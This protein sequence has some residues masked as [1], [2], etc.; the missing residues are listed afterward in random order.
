MKKLLGLLSLV[1]IS[2][3]SFAQTQAEKD[4]AILQ[5]YFAEHKIKATKTPSGLY[6]VINQKGS[7]DNAKAGQNVTV[8][9]TGKLLDGK[10][11]D[12]NVDPQFNHVQPFSFTLGNHQV[13]SGWDEGI[14]HY[15]KGA[16]GT[17]YVPSTLG[18][19]PQSRGPLPANAI[20]IFDVELVDAK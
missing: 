5:K 16:K 8:N 1:S 9:Y 3:V 20:M 10:P 14:A 7:G 18:Y 13:I 11:F 17:L 6:Y 12:S 2:F 4:D 15:N 19:G